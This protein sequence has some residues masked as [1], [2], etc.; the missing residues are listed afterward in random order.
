MQDFWK[1]ARHGL[2]IGLGYIS[3]SFAFGMMAVSEGLS[4]WQALVI[5]MAN[6]TSAGQLAGL[7]LMSAGAPLIE[8]ALT[9][10]IIN[11]RYALMSIS[12]SQKLDGSM[13]SLHRALVAFCNTDEVF[14]V[15]SSQPGSL[16]RRYLYG[17][18]ITPYIGWSLG[19]FL[20]AAAGALLPEALC[21][22]LGIAIYGM[23]LA[24]IIPPAKKLKSVRVAVILSALLSCAMRY[25]PVLNRISGG[26]VIIICAVSVSAFC[27]RFFP[28]KEVE[29]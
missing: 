17:L 12:L 16:N 13:N 8:M 9:Q 6:V 7:T 25:L 11:L 23:F 18:T 28:I 14:A 20:G 21:A 24:I 10:L 3:V 22:A 2:P 4:V 15:A 1:G 5:S 26:F 19:T 27:A 29:E